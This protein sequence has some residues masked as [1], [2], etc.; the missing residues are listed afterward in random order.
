MLNTKTDRSTFARRRGSDKAWHESASFRPGLFEQSD[1]IE[2]WA[3]QSS[4]DFEIV[5]LPLL[6]LAPFGEHLSI[7]DSVALYRRDLDGLNLRQLSIQNKIYKPVQ[8]IEV[9]QFFKVQAEK[10]GLILETAGVLQDG[11]RYW[12]AASDGTSAAIG[13]SDRINR[14]LTLVTSSDGTLATHGFWS[15][16]RVVCNNTLRLALAA[17]NAENRH[18]QTHRGV[19]D[20]TKVSINVGLEQA[21]QDW[22]QFVDS[23]NELAHIRPTKRQAL[24]YLRVIW[25]DVTKSMEEQTDVAARHM[26][27]CLELYDGKGQGSHLDSARDTAWGLL[28]SVTEYVDHH[29]RAHSDDNRLNRAW[30]GPGSASKRA[31]YELALQLGRSAEWMAA[32]EQYEARV[33]DMR[34]NPH[35][36]RNNGAHSLQEAP[37]AVQPP[38]TATGAA[39]SL[40][41]SLLNR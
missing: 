18:R 2:T 7:D 32:T 40:F 39:P 5:K 37:T 31:A 19:F 23:A 15:S 16:V 33:R 12:A 17:Q 10:A 24:E 34:E 21:Q 30:F 9:L 27:S 28:N 3:E 25:G 20:P 29:Q 1:P 11:R 4:F 36:P 38:P 22:S 6:A 8:P 35:H 41:E 26:T 14:Y 13:K